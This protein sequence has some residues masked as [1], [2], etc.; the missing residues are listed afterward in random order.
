MC[1]MKSEEHLRFFVG[2]W[3]LQKRRYNFPEGLRRCLGKVFWA[4]GQCVKPPLSVSECWLRHCCSPFPLC[5]VDEPQSWTWLTAYQY[6]VKS[7]VLNLSVHLPLKSE[8]F[9]SLC[10][11]SSL[12]PGN[13]WQC[14]VA[15]VR[16][17]DKDLSKEEN[18]GAYQSHKET[19][20]SVSSQLPP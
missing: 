6:S 3:F 10:S 13:P 1:G 14:Y 20:L 15:S 16:G 4:I 7:I 19:T 18:C 17:R 8:C 2:D 9:L 12:L 11:S 5:P